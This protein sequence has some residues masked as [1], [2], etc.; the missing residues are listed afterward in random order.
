M[1]FKVLDK[2]ERFLRKKESRSVRLSTK[3][4]HTGETVRVAGE[5]V[6]LTPKTPLLQELDRIDFIF[7]C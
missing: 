6:Q 7:Q 4:G 5:D 3:Q 1:R 2:P